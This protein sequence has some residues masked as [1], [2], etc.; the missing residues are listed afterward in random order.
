MAYEKETVYEHKIF[1]KKTKKI[2][3]ILLIILCVSVF[4][5]QYLTRITV[6]G[7]LD[8]YEDEWYVYQENG[9]INH[10]I[11]D[12]INESSLQSLINKYVVVWGGKMKNDEILVDKIK[13][14][15]PGGFP[16]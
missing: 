15:I 2:G 8:Y 16:P 14:Y 11:I 1:K 3:I 6:V 12:K 13:L 4:A 9:I 10:L 5:Y 7:V